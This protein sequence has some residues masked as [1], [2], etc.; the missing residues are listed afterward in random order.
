MEMNGEDSLAG[1]GNVN[2]LR[3]KSITTGDV[4]MFNLKIELEKH[5]RHCSNIPLVSSCIKDFYMKNYGNSYENKYLA[6]YDEQLVKYAGKD[7]LY[8]ETG[9]QVPCQQTKY[10]LED[11]MMSDINS[12]NDP[13]IQNFLSKQNS[14]GNVSMIVISHHKS[15]TIIQN[16]EILEYDASRIISEVGGI[17]GIF[18]GLS[19]WSIYLDICEPILLFIRN[20]FI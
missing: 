14:G 4:N 10:I 20:N 16:E 6:T 1:T 13:E 17:V 15:N 9:C 12:M 18:I 8:E 7:K 3:T 2:D 5:I 19:F 11:F